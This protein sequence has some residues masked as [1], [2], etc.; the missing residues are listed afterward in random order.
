MGV[1]F[2]ARV[3]LG[4]LAILLAALA[5]APAGR[6]QQPPPPDTAAALA[7]AKLMLDEIEAAAGRAGASGR[8]LID[9]RAQS[10][11]I[12]DDLIA[13]AADITAKRTAAEAQLKDLGPAP[14]DGRAEPAAIAAERTRLTA[15]V[16][17]LGALEFELRCVV[18]DFDR[19]LIVKSDLYF[20]I[21]QRLRAAGIRIPAPQREVR[22]LGEAAVSAKSA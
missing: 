9:L 17:D 8:A 15:L 11:A 22:L 7:S 10:A 12:H 20:A 19:S 2:A 14:A 21:L 4:A 3:A 18:A 16:A 5:F 13:K 1:R 6:A